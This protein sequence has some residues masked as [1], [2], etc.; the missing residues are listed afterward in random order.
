[1]EHSNIVFLF[2]L[3]QL[4]TTIFTFPTIKSSLATSSKT[5]YI[6]MLLVNYFLLG[7]RQWVLIIVAILVSSLI[8][9]RLRIPSEMRCYLWLKNITRTCF[10]IS[11][12]YTSMPYKLKS[13]HSSPVINVN[14]KTWSPL[15]KHSYHAI[16]CVNII[17]MIGKFLRVKK[18]TGRH[19]D[20]NSS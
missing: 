1:M 7:T 3:Y 6:E 18:Q 4:L 14:N 15:T 11:F 16:T 9:S 13:L 8:P 20:G 19:E 17:E 10:T 2:L 5:W 12:K